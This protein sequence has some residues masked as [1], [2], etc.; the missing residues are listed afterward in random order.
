MCFQCHG[1]IMSEV[2]LHNLPGCT[3]CNKVIR[4]KQYKW[5]KHSFIPI[6][7]NILIAELVEVKLETSKTLTVFTEFEASVTGILSKVNE[8]LGQEDMLILT[9]SQG[10]KI[11]DSEGTKGIVEHYL[12]FIW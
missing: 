5:V 3:G 4:P 10:K 12:L 6:F 1:Y 9:N 11:L 7:W 8:A 2:Y